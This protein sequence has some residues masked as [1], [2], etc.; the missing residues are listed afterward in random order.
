M[1][2]SF[3][4]APPPQAAIAVQGETSKFPVRRVW[5]V[6][7]NYLE[8]IRE[9]GELDFA[10]AG[11]RGAPGAL[12][13]PLHTEFGWSMSIMSI[14]MSIN[15]VLYGLVTPFAAALM[16]RFGMRRVVAT[17]L[18]LIAVGAVGSV[19]MTASWQ[20]LVFWGLLI[21]GGLLTL[22]AL[23]TGVAGVLV[24]RLRRP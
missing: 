24:L 1:T 12:M 17:A 14:A 7:R 19:V 5:C 13:V 4:I 3:V 8:H 20:L 22:M 21:G 6:G 10:A 15:L 2:A 18:T 23:L 9:L 16:D 11:F